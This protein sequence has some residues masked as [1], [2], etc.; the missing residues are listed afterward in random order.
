MQ[1]CQLPDYSQLPEHIQ[2][3]LKSIRC[4]ALVG[5]SP[6]P[7]RP[8]HQV[9]HYLLAQGFEVWPVNPGQDEILGRKC[10]PSISALP[11]EAKIDTVVIFRRP[12]QVMPI[13]E[14]AIARG[15]KVIW[16]QEG[17]VNREAAAR[18]KAAGIEVVMN[19][20]LKKVHQLLKVDGRA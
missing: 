2:E 8:S 19:L 18:A 6:K 13:V 16:M 17:I 15:V 4:I 5:A 14:E 10:Y 9:L 20:C 1:A 12:D 11:P 7:Q 3:I